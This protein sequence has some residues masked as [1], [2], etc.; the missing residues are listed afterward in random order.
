[1]DKEKLDARIGDVTSDAAEAE[2]I[3][4]TVGVLDAVVQERFKVF[5]GQVN[6]TIETTTR[7]VIQDA[8]KKEREATLP[9]AD[10]KRRALDCTGDHPA[11][12]NERVAGEVP[13][14]FHGGRFSD[15]V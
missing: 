4:K 2:R 6:T 7:S 3:S 8:L 14:A 1:M 5:E 13:R 11:G 12:G 15:G 10:P 9:A